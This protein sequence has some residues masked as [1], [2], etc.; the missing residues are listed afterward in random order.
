MERPGN[1]WSVTELGR[2]RPRNDVFTDDSSVGARSCAS[3]SFGLNRDVPLPSRRLRD[4]S[5]QRW[6]DTDEDEHDDG[7]LTDDTRVSFS[8]SD[9]ESELG[10]YGEG[11][12]DMMIGAG[13]SVP[14]RNRGL[15]WEPLYPNTNPTSSQ[16]SSG[17]CR[18]SVWT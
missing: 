11:N 18:T 10:E 8:F 5:K 12:L 16:G 13:G 7:R 15:G 14:I 6:H 9:D 1:R 2:Y 4:R 3:L 17:A